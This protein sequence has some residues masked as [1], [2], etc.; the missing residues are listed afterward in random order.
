MVGC[1]NP[2]SEVV[3]EPPLVAVHQVV[4]MDPRIIAIFV[5]SLL[6]LAG[7]IWYAQVYAPKQAPVP[8]VVRRTRHATSDRAVRCRSRRVAHKRRKRLGG[9]HAMKLKAHKNSRAISGVTAKTIV[10]NRR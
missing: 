5:A 6:G 7:F 3:D 4:M 9:E 2:L 10:S 8:V 1:I